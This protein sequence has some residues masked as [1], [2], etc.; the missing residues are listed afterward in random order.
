MIELKRRDGTLIDR[1]SVPPDA[2]NPLRYAVE[3][4]KIHLGGADLGGADLRGA[5]LR[6]ADLSAADL[7]GASLRHADLRGA[8]LRHA[9]LSDADLR[10]ADVTGTIGLDLTGVKVRP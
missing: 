6:H 10:G 3:R 5:D 1:V 9:D 2:R 7:R 8:N 4:K